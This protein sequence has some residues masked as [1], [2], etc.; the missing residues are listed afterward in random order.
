[1][2]LRA[3]AGVGVAAILT[4]SLIAFVLFGHATTP[5]STVVESRPA[6]VKVVAAKVV[7]FGEWTE[8]LGATLPLPNKAARISAAVA[9]RVLTILGDGKAKPLA[10][11]DLVKE[12]QV[13]VQLDDSVPRAY[14]DK[15]AAMLTDLELQKKQAQAAL[16]RAEAEVK[17]AA[18]A[19][20]EKA[21]QAR[22]DAQSSQAAT[23]SWLAVVQAELKALDAQLAHFSIRAPFAGEL[24][25]IQVTPG[26]AIVVGTTVADVINLE[27]IDVLCHVP[28]HT[29]ARLALG[30]P[31]RRDP[32]QHPDGKVVFIAAQA[33]AETGNFAV[34]VRFPN[35]DGKLRANR[36]QHVQ[37][38]TQPEKDRLTIPEDALLEDQSPPIVVGAIKLEEPRGGVGRSRRI[39]AA[40]RLRPVLGVHDRDLHL[41]EILQLRSV[42]TGD[43]VSIRDVRFIIE[44]GN[45]LK[46]N[47][48]LR[49]EDVRSEPRDDALKLEEALLK[50][51]K[52][53]ATLEGRSEAVWSL[54]FSPD[55]KLLASGNHDGIIKFWNAATGKNTVTLPKQT[56]GIFAVAFSPDG[57]TLASGSTNGIIQLWDVGTAKNIA[58]FERHGTRVDAVVFSPDGKSLASASYDGFTKASTIKLW[59]MAN[60]KCT[61]TLL[62]H[63]EDIRRVIFSPDGKMLASGSEDM[64]VKIWDAVSGKN[65]HTFEGPTS[66]ISALAFSQDG[67]KVLSWSKVVGKD[68]VASGKSEIMV[69]DLDS[70]KNITTVEGDTGT[71]LPF[72]GT[73]SPD[74]KTLAWAAGEKVVT[75]WD[76]A[77]A[78]T[79]A[80]L[81]GHTGNVSVLAFSSDG[82]SM[83]TASEDNTIKLWDLPSATR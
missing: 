83:A 44:G 81:V 56:S 2:S 26:Q 24:G 8:L 62:G 80:T 27:E 31:A 28:P 16:D 38:L 59:N 65:T 46:D 40:L 42:Q 6:P 60:G 11:G 48:I 25:L 18:Q 19:D 61:A 35:K 30:Q 32:R 64:T 76:G 12:N 68:E 78:K 33:E 7:K 41:V 14:R 15:L 34:K 58:T 57:K 53:R 9:G 67:K 82:K 49:A 1:M 22:F 45:G 21:R 69:W 20:M 51:L 39:K 50:T 71:K 54:A 75:L 43:L 55:G 73:F 70:G 17:R 66:A 37:V 52:E 77:S 5:V 4:A 47:D 74:G 72:L 23:E 36:V 3:L 79:V 29:A 13:I 63:E 10:E